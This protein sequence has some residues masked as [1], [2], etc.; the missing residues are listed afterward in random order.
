VE[1]GPSA[2]GRPS[3]SIESSS[4]QRTD[5]RTL[6]GIPFVGR[7]KE[8]LG[9]DA[10][11]EKAHEGRR[12]VVFVTGSA[13]IGKTA[14]M[15]AFVERAI[16]TAAAPVWVLRG[17]CVEQHG[18]REPYMPVLEALERLAHHPD[19]TR[20]TRLLRRVA[21]TWL[22]QMTCLI[23]PD[24]AD[25]LRQSLQ[26]VTP[27]RMLREFAVLMEAVA[28]DVT[29]ILVMEDLHWSDASTVDLLSVLGQRPDPARLLVIGTYRQA[30]AIVGEHVLM[31]AVR[32]L[33]M[34]RRSVELALDDLSEE[35]VSEYLDARFPGNDF[36][37]PLARVIRAHTDGNPLFMVGVVDHMLSR[38][39]I[40]D[41]APGWALHSPLDKIDLGVP[42]DVRLL[43]EDQFHGLS[44]ADRALVQAAS[45]AGNGFTP[46]VV[47]AALGGDVADIETR[48]ATFARA[49]RFLRVAGRVEWPDR[50]V[51]DRYAFT[52]ELYRQVV[53][54]EI[55]DGQCMRLHQRIGQAL[56]AAHGARRMEIAAQLAVH[57]ERGHDDERA[58]HYFR[59]AAARARERFASREAIGYLE[60]AL[61]LVSLIPHHGEQCRRELELRLSLGAALADIHGF[62]AE[63]VREN[64]ELASE[65]C[66]K[67]GTP[68]QLFE[69]LYARWYLHA[70]RAERAE[71][72]ALAK[73]LGDLARR[74]RSRECRVAADSASMRTALYDGRF[75]DAVEIMEGP[76]A[77]RR[78]AT[79]VAEPVAYGAAPLIVAT[80]HHA[81]ALW[82]LGDPER[83]QTTAR[84]A[85]AQARASGHYFTIAAV[86]IQAAIVEIL[87]R[88]V[89]AVDALSVEAGALSAEHGFRLWSALASLVRAWT[90]AQRDEPA[91][92][93]AVI[94]SALTAMAATG[95]RYFS[96]FGYGFLAEAHLRAGAI[97]EGLAAAEAGLVVAHTTLDRA[98]GPELWRLKGEL[99]LRIER[100]RIW[101]RRAH[102]HASSTVDP[103]EPE[104]CLL[105]AL[106]LA[107]AAGAKSLELRAATSVARAWAS[108]GRAPEASQLLGDACRWFGTRTETADLLDARALLATLA[109]GAIGSSIESDRRR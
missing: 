58:L 72:I 78:L 64:Y 61:G 47:A 81:I 40:L 91:E 71:A 29:V 70:I 53:Y 45:V 36:A 59:A 96:A 75:R 52:H 22:A 51:T 90:S 66:T 62:A 89:D 46:L 104:R 27:Q 48:C 67:V 102:A 73:Q 35:A 109:E 37:A 14:L 30:D 44:P 87:R 3:P 31:S 50:N 7:G 99:L 6:V 76:L 56:E 21:P 55:S 107:G 10:L 39:Q 54:A 19:A 84:A 100:S 12:Q 4:L 82:F 57:F 11:L 103:S 5:Q 95:A 20:L 23:G 33:Q 49:H 85:V 63:P 97:S 26:I 92:G 108:R 18:P 42:D 65:L 94:E 106:E 86:L 9:L 68:A 38:G 80:S 25:A 60:P 13:G 16:R 69:I 43:I 15:D 17:G 2:S 105:H 93:A 32:A 74:L 88:N 98:Y 8:L 79:F 1:A 77:G 41:T 101:H 24:E 83:A 28:T 34:H